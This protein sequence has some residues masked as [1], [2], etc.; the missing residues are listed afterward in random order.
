M[1]IKLHRSTQSVLHS[2]RSFMS[3][4]SPVP[5]NIDDLNPGERARLRLLWWVITFAWVAATLAVP[6]AVTLV[7][8][9][10][11]PILA[12]AF[13]VGSWFLRNAALGAAL[14]NLPV[15]RW[16]SRP[17]RCVVVRALWFLG[18]TIFIGTC[19]SLI[20]DA[21]NSATTGAIASAVQYALGAMLCAFI[22]RKLLTTRI[23]CLVV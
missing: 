19:L 5:L 3:G 23:P 6:W 2:E 22:T 12:P 14:R 15:D 21:I 13:W 18:F 8:Q 1:V 4:I 9:N 7:S 17:L 20:V 10:M 16:K 11:M